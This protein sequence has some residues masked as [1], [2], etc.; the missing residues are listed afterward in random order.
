MAWLEPGSEGAPQAL[1]YVGLGSNLEDPQG[2]ILCA[3]EA[4][5]VL[6]DCV[7]IARSE[8]YVTTPLG[9]V[10][11]PEYINAA[12]TLATRIPPLELLEAL[13]RIERIQGRRRDGTRWGPRTL[14]LDLLLYGDRH[15]CGP[16]LRLPHPEIHRRA[17]VL[18]PL[19]QIAPEGL[20][21]P[22]QG[23]LGDLLASCPPDPGMRPVRASA[24]RLTTPGSRIYPL[25]SL[26]G[27]YGQD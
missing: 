18:V 15:L 4:L 11:Q 20:V 10:A 22:G 26:E 12:A 25:S 16:R 5:S 21:I 3:L 24:L 6:P 19:A 17:F 7:L 27:A 13:Q 8:L 2:Q 1:A 9:P 14:D 23:R